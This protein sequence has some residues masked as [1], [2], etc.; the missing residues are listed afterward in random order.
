MQCVLDGP[1]G[2]RLGFVLWHWAWALMPDDWGV[3]PWAAPPT[4][5]RSCRKLAGSFPISMLQKPFL[6]KVL[7]LPFGVV[8]SVSLRPRPLPWCDFVLMA[9]L[10]KERHRLICPYNR[11]WTVLPHLLCGIALCEGKGYEELSDEFGL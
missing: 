9:L 2:A 4:L 3:A 10:G 11:A 1:I 7:V 8:C 5:P 6:G